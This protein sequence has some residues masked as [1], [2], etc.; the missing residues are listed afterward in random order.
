MPVIEHVEVATGGVPFIKTGDY[1]TIRIF[2]I[3]NEKGEKDKEYVIKYSPDDMDYLVKNIGK[4]VEFEPVSP[5]QIDR[6]DIVNKDRFGESYS[7]K[8]TGAVIKKR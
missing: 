5:S 1:D 7:Y 4:N 2:I 3:T 6:R 8:F